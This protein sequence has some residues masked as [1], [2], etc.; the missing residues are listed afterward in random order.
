MRLASPSAARAAAIDLPGRDRSN[1]RSDGRYEPRQVAAAVT[2]IAVLSAAPRGR[3][4]AAPGS[5]A[6]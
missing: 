1:W 3:L 6:W 4:V 2:A 5:V